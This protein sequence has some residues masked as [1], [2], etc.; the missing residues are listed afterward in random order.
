M[1]M[2][3]VSLVPSAVQMSQ[4]VLPMA[5]FVAE[6]VS[7]VIQYPIRSVAEISYLDY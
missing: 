7:S 6:V 3:P 2:V 5:S 4:D 1:G